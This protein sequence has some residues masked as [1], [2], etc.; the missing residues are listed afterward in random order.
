ME[1]FDMTVPLHCIVHAE[2]LIDALVPTRSWNSIVFVMRSEIIII[3]MNFIFHKHTLITL[4]YNKHGI[5]ENNKAELKCSYENI[6]CIPAKLLKNY[7]YVQYIS[8]YMLPE[9]KSRT[10][11]KHSIELMNIHTHSYIISV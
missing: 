8:N 3:T 10:H 2:R 9:I 6:M 5:L 7:M 4:K 11:L 1:F